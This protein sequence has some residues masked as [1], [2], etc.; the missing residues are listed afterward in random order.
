M[1]RFL[2]AHDLGTSG[3]KATL[4]TVDGELVAAKTH[5][6]ETN[7]FHQ[8][9]AEQNP[10]DWW[11][12]VCGSTRELLANVD[13]R[14]IAAVALS[15]QMMGCLCVDR[16]GEPLGPSIIYC[17]Q[18]AVEQTERLLEKLS[19]EEFYRITGHRASA[20][21]SIE[22]LMWLKDHR[23]DVY[24]GT[25]K[26]L[27][28]KDYVNFR[29]TGRMATD[30][31]DASG[32]NA[33]DLG[34]Y[35]WSETI[36]D[37]A[38]IDAAGL[39]EVL[40]STEVL[41][42]VSP[43][44]AE[45][46]GLAAG[47]PVVVGGGDGSCAAVGVGCIAPGMAYN[48]VGSSSWIGITSTSPVNDPQM[49]TVS[50]AHIL[51]RHVHA[52]GTMQTAC[53]SFNWLKNEICRSETEQAR[54]EQISPY[55][56]MDRQ[57]ESS[58]PGARGLLFL[59]YL[60]GERSPRWDPNAKGAFLGLNLSHRREDLLRAVLEGITLNLEIIL[61]IF[62]EHVEIDAMTVI[63]GGAK[64]RVW[65]QIM[66]DVYN[67][68]IARPNVLEEATS[69]GA[70]VIGGVGAGVF[71]GFEV[72]DRFI[73]IESKQQPQSAARETYRRLM[74]VFDRS[75]HALREVCDELTEI[76]AG[77]PTTA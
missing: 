4:F 2:L 5:A 17:D 28:A 16:R 9:W 33:F 46:T 70:A 41:G 53:A 37:A 44:A 45:A 18:R 42:G 76:A 32:T 68:E 19:P 3:N 51:P 64:S 65:R 24:Q 57:I 10:A 8:N 1:K 75:Y 39:P 50:W 60:L 22:K 38:E 36:L 7:Y 34:E 71:D 43:E 63:G 13:P 27:N 26:M 23:P 52:A 59:P 62:R 20:S 29:L 47:T 40:D 66:A 55:V 67:L 61:G 15:G 30:P 73:R 54:R 6:Y 49:R 11:E 48:Y 12:A 58:P 74:P 72:I 25:H 14:E 21:Y 31:S 35:C 56:L 69:M 77:S